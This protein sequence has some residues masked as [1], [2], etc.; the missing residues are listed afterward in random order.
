M[1]SGEEQPAT[2]TLPLPKASLVN[3]IE[4]SEGAVGHAVSLEPL[5][6]APFDVDAL[7]A[8]LDAMGARDFLLEELPDDP[9]VEPEDFE[10]D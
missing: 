9:P 10:I 4:G 7:W 5:E 3:G 2:E 1:T 6:P 8:K